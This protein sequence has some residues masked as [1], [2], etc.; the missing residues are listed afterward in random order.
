MLE[1]IGLALHPHL[2]ATGIVLKVNL[3]GHDFF[4]FWSLVESRYSFFKINPLNEREFIQGY[5]QFLVH[6]SFSMNKSELL[7]YLDTISEIEKKEIALFIPMTFS[8]KLYASNSDSKLL[9]HVP[10]E[11]KH[12][13]YSE[14]HD[15]PKTTLNEALKLFEKQSS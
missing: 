2:S 15:V 11:G 3:E 1:L 9:I 10:P 12:S 4:A 8:D 7:S 14:I 5:F 13:S 6:R